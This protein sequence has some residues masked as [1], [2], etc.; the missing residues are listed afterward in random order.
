MAPSTEVS[1]FLFCIKQLLLQ[2]SGTKSFGPSAGLARWGVLIYM[3]IRDEISLRLAEGRLFQI[4]PTLPGA[5]VVRVLPAG[6]DVY[7]LVT[8]PWADRQEEVRCGRLWA[9]F[10]RL[11]E[12]RLVSVALDNPYEKPKS[13]Y[14]ARMDPAATRFGRF[15]AATQNPAFVC[16]GALPN[17][18]FS[19][20]R[21]GNVAN[22]WA[23]QVHAN[24][25]RKFKSRRL[26][27]EN[28]FPPI[29]RSREPK[30]MT[31]SQT[32][33]LSEIVANEPIPP[34]KLAYFRERF[35]DRLYELV[36]SEFL[37]KEQAGEITRA[38]LARRIGRKPEQITRWLG[39]PGNWT[40]ETVS[41]LLLAISK[42]ELMF[43]LSNLDRRKLHNYR[44]P[45]WLDI[46][47][48]TSAN[49]LA[50]DS[51]K[52]SSPGTSQGIIP[53]RFAEHVD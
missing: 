39:A 53:L 41:D 9:D 4:V 43:T 48:I 6:P 29:R 16:S 26:N 1:L 15:E 37:K 36:V 8:G 2:C 14:L 20:R 27:G 47:P 3:S 44:G 33:F 10:D 52:T 40:L 22:G 24:S 12:G 42:A 32:R 23:D 28:Y 51:N 18:T 13:T 45:E 35:R 17:A 21:I 7:R 11:T 38:D 19:S 50:L 25:I 49:T 31:T 5:S 34:G 46:S 30:S